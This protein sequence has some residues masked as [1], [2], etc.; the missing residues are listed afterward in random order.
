LAALIH[1]L[2]LHLGQKKI[3]RDYKESCTLSIV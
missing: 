3:P 2:S 1:M